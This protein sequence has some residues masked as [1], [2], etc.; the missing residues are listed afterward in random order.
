LKINFGNNYWTLKPKK[1]YADIKPK[2]RKI[3][4]N[5][6]KLLKRIYNI[7]ADENSLIYSDGNFLYI[8]DQ[9]RFFV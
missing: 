5:E 8:K 1:S 9:F 3:T 6:I 2:M 4:K 7:I